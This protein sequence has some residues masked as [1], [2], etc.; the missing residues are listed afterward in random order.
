MKYF[1]RQLYNSQQGDPSSEKTQK[2]Y[3][4]W[5]KA[6]DAYD[7]YYKS[8]EL[9]LPGHIKS[10]KNLSFHDAEIKGFNYLNKSKLIVGV[11]GVDCPWR[12]PGQFLLKFEGVK[13]FEAQGT[14]VGDGWLYE[15]IHLGENGYF[16]Y[17]VLLDESEFQ[18][19]AKDVILEEVQDSGES[20]RLI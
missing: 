14:I 15:E 6:V 3:E 2:A 10:L 9:F 16:E 13:L 8:V 12:A 18:V 1:T 5:K 19:V 20:K 4:Q 11:D 17:H 7:V